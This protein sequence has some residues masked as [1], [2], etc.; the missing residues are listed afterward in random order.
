MKKRTLIGCAA[1]PVLALA[2]L[3]QSRGVHAQSSMSS[4]RDSPVY[5]GILMKDEANGQVYRVSVKDGHLDVNKYT[6]PIVEAK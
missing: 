3:P 6:K 4:V 5:S 1:I 2:F